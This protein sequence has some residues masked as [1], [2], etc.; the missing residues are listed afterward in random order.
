MDEQLL[1]GILIVFF[2]CITGALVH[3]FGKLNTA[4]DVIEAYEGNGEEIHE[5]IGQIGGALAILLERSEDLMSSNTEQPNLL[6]PLID[7]FVKNISGESGLSMGST[8]RD[9]TGRYT[10]ASTPPQIEVT[11]QES[12]AD[13]ESSSND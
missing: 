13:G 12:Q 4:L 2:A 6:K 3:I 7:A 11:T 10:H 8:S 5:A 9:S 1:T